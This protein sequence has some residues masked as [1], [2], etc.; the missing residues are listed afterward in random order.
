[1]R[2]SS[3]ER[4]YGYICVCIRIIEQMLK[5]DKWLY[6]PICHQNRSIICKRRRVAFGESQRI[7]GCDIASHS[8]FQTGWPTTTMTT[9]TTNRN[10]TFNLTITALSKRIHRWISTKFARS[11]YGWVR[12]LAPYE[13]VTRLRLYVR[14]LNFQNCTVSYLAV[15]ISL[16]LKL[17]ALRN[18]CNFLVRYFRSQQIGERERELFSQ[19]IDK[20]CADR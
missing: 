8:R 7:R 14:R 15:T 13:W 2:V 18:F 9:T 10:E 3:W 1:M 11:I 5:W 16:P 19:I 12:I 20:I 4:V 17:V 6:H